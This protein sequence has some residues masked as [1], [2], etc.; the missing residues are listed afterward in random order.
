M[1]KIIATAQIREMLRILNER[2]FQPFFNDEQELRS[3][4]EANTR[5]PSTK[6]A[7]H[8]KN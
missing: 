3:W 8:M 6:P 5:F 2:Y 4:F 7:A 1:V